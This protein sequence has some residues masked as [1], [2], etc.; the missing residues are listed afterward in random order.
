[1]TFDPAKPG[2]CPGGFMGRTAGGEHLWSIPN[3]ITGQQECL[4]C[5][6]RRG[7]LILDENVIPV[8]R[9]RLVNGTSLR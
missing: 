2:D 3:R 4:F 1:M 8:R 9:R 6:A 5:Y 7:P